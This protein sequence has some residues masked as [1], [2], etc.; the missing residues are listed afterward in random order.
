[1]SKLLY[2]S[3][4]LLASLA[5]AAE[6][7]SDDVPSQ[8]QE[9]CAPV[10]SLAASCDAQYDDD[11]RGE[12]NCICSDSTSATNIPLCASCISQF[13]HDRDD[14]DANDLVRDCSFTTTSYNPTSTSSATGTSTITVSSSSTSTSSSQTSTR[15][16]VVTTTVTATSSATEN[17]VGMVPEPG[18]GLLGSVV[19][20][21]FVFLGI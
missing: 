20:G 10:V 13:S 1:M 6:I 2:L 11:D 12:K 18:V 17:A 3:A 21:L 14:N 15:G 5:A 19:L 8:C 7:D 9:V 16:N 4:L